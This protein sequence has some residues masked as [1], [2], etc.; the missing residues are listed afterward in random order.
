MKPPSRPTTIRSV[1]ATPTSI[2]RRV[3]SYAPVEESF[4]PSFI[5][6][7]LPLS[8]DQTLSSETASSPDLGSTHRAARRR[9]SRVRFSDAALPPAYSVPTSTAGVLHQS[10]SVD[11]LR[12]DQATRARAISTV[13]RRSSVASFSSITSDPFALQ[14]FA[15]NTS[16]HSPTSDNGDSDGFYPQY[17]P[18]PRIS[19]QLPQLSIGTATATSSSPT[20]GSRAGSDLFARSSRTASSSSP[21]RRPSYALSLRDD[22]GSFASITS[23]L[24]LSEQLSSTGSSISHGVPLDMSYTSLLPFHTIGLHDDTRHPPKINRDAWLD[25]IGLSPRSGPVILSHDEQGRENHENRQARR[26]GSLES[27]DL[28]PAIDQ[29][30]KEVS[31]A[32]KHQRSD[33]MLSLAMDFP[34]PPART[35]SLSVSINDGSPREI[36]PKAETIIIGDSASPEKVVAGLDPVPS[37]PSLKEVMHQSSQARR[38]QK[39][40]TEAESEEDSEIG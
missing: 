17:L 6:P 38:M 28:L 15:S 22:R 30:V 40:S 12:K 21:F 37:S 25:D 31:S 35:H 32:G 11:E 27:M 9:S 8:L 20:S 18:Y 34:I 26:I 24:L 3:S 36:E 16:P 4:G 13:P 2:L 29:S 19:S 39:L 23:T 5:T 10:Y 1:K 7:S 14:E 33:C